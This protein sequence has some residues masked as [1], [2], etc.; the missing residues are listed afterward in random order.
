MNLGTILPVQQTNDGV[1]IGAG[2]TVSEDSDTAV[3]FDGDI[4]EQE[5]GTTGNG[6]DR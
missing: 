5:S 6:T 3:R 2:E 4:T 1:G